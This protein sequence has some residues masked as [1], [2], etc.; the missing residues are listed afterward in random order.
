MIRL[1]TRLALFNLLS[2]VAVTLLFIVI[3]PWIIERINLRQVDNDLVQKREQIIGLIGRIG[4]E[5]FISTDTTVAFGSYNIL[6][7]EFVSL[8]KTDLKEELNNIEVS[9]RIIEDE[10]I[11]YRVLD[12]TILVDGQKYLLE[13]GRSLKSIQIAQKNIYRV[14]LV[15]VILI[16]LITFITDLQ[17]NRFLLRPLGKI[18]DKLKGIS[19]P[20]SFDRTPVKTSTSDF[21]RLDN[22]LRELMKNIGELFEKEKEITDNVSH[23]LLTPVS[24]LRSK[25]ENL[26]LRDDIDPEITGKIEELLK[27]LFRLQSLVNSLLFIAR[28]ESRQ[29][30]MED[31]FNTNEVLREIVEEI[32]PIAEDKGVIINEEINQDYQ[33]KGANRSLIFSMFSNVINNAIKNTS[34]GGHVTIKSFNSGNY[35]NVTISDNGCGMSKEQIDK[36]FSRFKAKVNSQEDGTG[37]GLAIAKTI[38]DFHKIVVSVTSE[39]EKGTSFSFILPEN[40]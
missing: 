39:I 24:V 33:L 40:S 16:I 1:K 32:K 37:I 27:T 23:E 12:Y 7:E 22:A 4:I 15:F 36:L 17:Y 29:Y 38:A 3:L 10:K 20:S 14:I 28:I 19:D 21:Y 8:E 30:L 2:K 35:F 11:S 25:L 31:T 13:I 34:S 6:M 26:L 5:P 18:T 9:D